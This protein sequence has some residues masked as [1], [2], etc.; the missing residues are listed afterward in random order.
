VGDLWITTVD[1]ALLR[2]TDGRATPVLPKGAVPSKVSALYAS[3]DGAV[4]IG[5]GRGFGRL[6]HGRFQFHSLGAGGLVGYVSAFAEDAPGDTWIGTV[7]MG[8][9]RWHRGRLE[10]FDRSE[11]LSRDQV[12]CLLFD[13]EGSLWVGTRGGLD[14]LRRGAVV[15]FDPRNG[16][17]PFPDPGALLWD[18]EGRFIVAGATAGLVTGG[19]G[20]WSAL[21]GVQAANRKIW[22]LAR[23]HDGIWIGGD[24]TLALFKGG[25]RRAYTARDGLAGKWMLAAAEDSLQRVWVGTDQGLF[26]LTPGGDGR[27]TAMTGLPHRYV[28]ALAVDRLG[29]VWVGTNGGLARFAT[30]SIQTFGPADGLSGP[31]VFTI[32]FRTSTQ[33][34]MVGHC[35]SR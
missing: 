34:R 7:G 19:P 12:T 17:P 11:G 32:R 31:L 33:S 29:A 15:T 16:G 18:R 30:D 28:R 26:R 10:Q 35:E 6:E 27:F 23:G 3:R 13:R 9:L 20:A 24:D 1:G 8:L 2:V 4:W 22:T 21:P 25:A 14:R 5:T